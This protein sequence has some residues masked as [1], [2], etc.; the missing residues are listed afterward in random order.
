MC[1]IE[2]AA[3]SHL[4]LY[5]VDPHSVD[6]QA[7]VKSPFPKNVVGWMT[8]GVF[9]ACERHKQLQLVL[10]TGAYQTCI[11]RCMSSNLFHCHTKARMTNNT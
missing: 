9:E 10:Q 8:L 11:F 3:E 1:L 4:L 2:Q 7:I 5:G 6:P